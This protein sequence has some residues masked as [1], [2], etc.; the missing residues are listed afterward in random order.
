MV[1]L[2]APST[3]VRRDAMMSMAWC[4]RPPDR[5][6]RKSS[7]S[8]DG[9]TPCTGTMSSRPIRYSKSARP[10]LPS[11]ALARLVPPGAA[12]ADELPT[13]AAR[14]LAQA[15]SVRARQ[16]V[17]HARV[18]R[19]FTTPSP[20][21]GRAPSAPVHPHESAARTKPLVHD[22]SDGIQEVVHRTSVGVPQVTAVHDLLQDVHG[23]RGQVVRVAP[24]AAEADDM[25]Q[26]DR[27]DLFPLLVVAGGG[28]VE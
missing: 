4:R 7:R 13:G 17:R 21:V 26:Q 19:S 2:S 10:M 25:A 8:E 23:F 22:D 20:R 12:G 1:P 6:A 11:V 14:P 24:V 16:A 28:V 18:A 9:A 5:A 15:P 3:R 27:R